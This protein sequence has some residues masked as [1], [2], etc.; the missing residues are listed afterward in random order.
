[1]ASYSII[2]DTTT[3][4]YFRVSVSIEVQVRLN[5]SNKFAY[6]AASV[7]KGGCDVASSSG[8]YVAINSNNYWAIYGDQGV[9]FIHMLTSSWSRGGRGQ[10]CV[11]SSHK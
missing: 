3:T 6:L 9:A 4:Y 1:M 5:Q 10:I 11:A 8:I 7:N 2:V